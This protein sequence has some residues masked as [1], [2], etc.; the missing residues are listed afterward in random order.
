[1]A[2]AKEAKA[3]SGL[4]IVFERSRQRGRTTLAGGAGGL[5][6]LALAQTRSQGAFVYLWDRRRSRLDLTVWRGLD[7]TPIERFEVEVGGAKAVWCLERSGTVEVPDKAW[8][9]WRF[10]D[11]PEFLEHRF[12]AV[13]S[14]PLLHR[15]GVVGIANLC[16]R[17]RLAGVKSEGD[18]L[19]S[20]GA[21]LGALVAAGWE[22]ADAA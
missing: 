9:D 10:E 20:L 11:F 18:Y 15:G 1:M 4:R 14:V 17:K 16:R 5:L 3:L 21:P 8:H 13:T 19:R 7:P 6:A 12:E 2:E 22:T